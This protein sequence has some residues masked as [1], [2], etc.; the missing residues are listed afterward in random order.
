MDVLSK[1]VFLKS[2]RVLSRLVGFLKQNTLSPSRVVFLEFTSQA[3][4]STFVDPTT[5]AFAGLI[6]A[7]IANAAISV[8][9]LVQLRSFK[10]HLES[11]IEELERLRD[12]A[13]IFARS[14][15]LEVTRDKKRSQ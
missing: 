3:N 2:L 15:Q 8:Q 10:F 11:S 9:R 12:S 13:C 6:A 4:S 5:F 7:K 14:V 1:N